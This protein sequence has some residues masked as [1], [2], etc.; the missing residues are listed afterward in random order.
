MQGSASIVIVFFAFNTGTEMA[1]ENAY[2][3]LQYKYYTLAAIFMFTFIN[4]LLYMK[5]INHAVFYLQLKGEDCTYLLNKHK[6][7]LENKEQKK[8]EQDFNEIGSYSHQEGL[9]FIKSIVQSLMAR[10][11]GYYHNIFYLFIYFYFLFY[12]KNIYF[13]YLY[14]IILLFYYFIIFYFIKS[15]SS[16]LARNEILLFRS[17]YWSLDNRANT[18]FYFLLYHAYYVVVFRR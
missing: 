6:K 11:T 18:R 2:I 10:G 16:L 14:I 8:I 4:L 5:E 9:D 1:K 7:S 13:Y 12:Y 15:I 3:F 17:F